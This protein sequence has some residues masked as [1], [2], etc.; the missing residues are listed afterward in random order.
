MMEESQQPHSPA[1]SSF[2]R[3]TGGA[4][5]VAQNTGVDSDRP[6]F[7]GRVESFR[8][9]TLEHK[10]QE[11]VD[12]EEIRDLVAV[13]A[14]RMAHGPAA[15]DLFT[16]DGAYI[17]RGTPDLPPREVRGR[18]ALDEYFCDRTGWAERPLPMIHNHLISVGGDEAMGICSVEI[19]LV[20]NSTSFVAS[21]Y[22]RDRYRRDNG[23][24]KFVERDAAFFHWVPLHQGWA[25]KP[26][27]E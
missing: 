13:Y 12:R 17:N 7:A 20:A 27:S 4:P 22:Y 1:Q 24:W 18:A 6:L 10:I 2:S 25:Q 15:A 16:D 14:H 3:L 26:T 23:C 21:G 9:Q 5:L 8:G 19:R 11:L